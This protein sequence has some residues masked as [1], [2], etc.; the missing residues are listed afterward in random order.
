MADT[1]RL[2]IHDT[3]QARHITDRLELQSNRPY[4]PIYRPGK[5]AVTHEAVLQQMP[6]RVLAPLPETIRQSRPTMDAPSSTG[7]DATKSLSKQPEMPVGVVEDNERRSR[8]DSITPEASPEIIAGVVYR[9]IHRN[10][11]LDRERR[12]VSDRPRFR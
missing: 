8:P 4:Y 7:T 2:V 3:G 6:A 12:P 1:R 5:Y 9:M 11:V 10:I